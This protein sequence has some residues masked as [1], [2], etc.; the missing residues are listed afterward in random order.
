MKTQKFF[1]FPILFLL[2][3]YFILFT[4]SPGL[5]YAKGSNSWVEKSN[6][7]TQLLL[8]IMSRFNPESA[9]QY[10]I[11]GIDENIIDVNPDFIEREIKADLKARKILE[12]RLES[13][14]IPEV[15]QDLQ[16]LISA[17]D[18]GVASTR[19]N[20]KYFLPY[21]NISELVFYSL[22]GLLD[23][24]ISEVRRPA[25]LIRIKK[26]T[27]MIDTHKPITELLQNYTE[28]K[29]K[30]QELLG[31]LKKEMERNLE[32]TP[33]YLAGIKDLFEK[34]KI[35][36]YQEAH[37]RLTQQLEVYES[38][39]RAKVMPR[40]RENFQ[41]PNEVYLWKSGRRNL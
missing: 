18:E 37:Q 20:Q 11:E 31:P 9:A 4:F 16:I 40:A 19:L 6:E 21:Y 7:N 38:F 36:N 24:Q 10:G 13:E 2:P 17:I 26:Y 25:A 32:N 5:I 41:L 28:E 27:G 1:I 39:L 29:L 22:Q 33:R 35:D 12:N 15:R 14:T 8:D 23:D 34:F 3:F 30:N